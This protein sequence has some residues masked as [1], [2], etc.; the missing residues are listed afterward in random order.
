MVLLSPKSVTIGLTVE[1]FNRVR[2]KGPLCISGAS[3]A[4]QI[5]AAK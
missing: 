2:L 3:I 1:I 4:W 5:G